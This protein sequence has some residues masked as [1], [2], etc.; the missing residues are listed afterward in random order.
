MF[1]LHISDKD[2][3]S[4][5]VPIS[6]CLDKE[7]LAKLA[8]RH[9]IEPM[10]V[11]VIAP[12][13]GYHPSKEV[14]KVVPMRE[15]MTYI[16]FHCAGENKI[17]GF[18][19][20]EDKGKT[21]RKFLKRDGNGYDTTVLNSENTECWYGSS[22]G[23]TRD[24]NACACL[25]VDVP[26]ECFAPEPSQWEKNWVNFFFRDKPIDQCNFRRRRIFAYT[27]QPFAFLFKMLGALPAILIAFLFVDKG[28]FE[29]VKRFLQPLTYPVDDVYKGLAGSILFRSWPNENEDWDRVKNPMHFLWFL[30]K[31]VGLLAF[32][33]V[34]LLGVWLLWHFHKLMIVLHVGGIALAFVFAILLAI[35]F[36]LSPL[37]GVIGKFFGNLLGKIFKYPLS[38]LTDFIRWAVK[39]L[40]P[41]LP[42]ADPESM[43]FWY[44]RPES[45]KLL[46]C[47]S[48]K[49]PLTIKAL[50]KEARSVKLYF[51]HIK[52][53]VC[54]PFS[55]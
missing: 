30:G 29:V 25:T 22:D 19:Y 39:K 53:K 16:D 50:P 28:F 5:T 51:Q 38:L 6:W 37:S 42:K 17:W 44:Q 26:K 48:E 31:K 24:I 27:L 2:V 47:T 54:R 15:L 36:V 13:K 9:I 7:L 23:F 52:S 8:K 35:T 18:V 49:K 14:R 41:R 43:E 32:M 21:E 55:R 40:F 20:G 1:E 12:T 11:I 33:P 3:T 45:E 10:L 46:V 4:G 34:V